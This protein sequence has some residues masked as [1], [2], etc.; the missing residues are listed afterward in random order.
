[1]LQSYSWYAFALFVGVSLLVYY[2]GLFVW[3][4]KKRWFKS[5]DSQ[6]DPAGSVIKRIWS[7]RDVK[8]QDDSKDPNTQTAQVSSSSG[9]GKRKNDAQDAGIILMPQVHDLLDELQAMFEG[10][11]DS[12]QKDVVLDSLYKILHKYPALLNS[13]Y[14]ENISN[15]IMVNCEKECALQLSPEEISRLW[16]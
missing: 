15:M 2:L 3:R 1:M 13:D 12:P 4:A 7:P 9:A 16:G 8:S 6:G 14:R 11:R 5:R 10:M